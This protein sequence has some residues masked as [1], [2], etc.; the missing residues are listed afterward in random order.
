MTCSLLLFSST[1]TDSELGVRTN[2][3]L[4]APPAFSVFGEQAND[5]TALP[6][7][8]EIDVSVTLLP[9]A[10]PVRVT[11][12]VATLPFR[13]AVMVAVSLIL[14]EPAVAVKLDVV[15]PA[16]TITEAGTDSSALLLA[17]V[18]L[19]PPAGAV[20]VSMIEQVLAAVG[21]ILVT[22]H[23]RLETRTGATRLM[24][25][26]FELLP[27]AAITVALWLLA[28]VAAAVALKVAVL[29]PAVTVTEAGTVSEALLLASD[30]LNPPVGAFWPSVTVHVL[31]A[32]CP[33]L[34]GLHARVDTRTGV[35]RLM[36]A[37]FELLP[38]VAV[39]VAV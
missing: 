24:T 26:V 33:R 17:S 31:T 32:L 8:C 1:A 13:E 16:G 2:S 9:L 30:T 23:A 35:S 38:R 7:S 29:V 12:A 10:T 3:Q 27:R 37:V 4:T 6:R 28:I 11:E 15:L 19:D 39:N 36:L 14:A 22:L 20:C 21:A 18:T 5:E 34:V 25:A